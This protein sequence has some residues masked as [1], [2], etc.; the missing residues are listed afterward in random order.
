M[1]RKKE[2]LTERVMEWAYEKWLDGYRIAEIAAAL[3]VSAG[4]LSEYFSS[5][6]Y[7]KVRPPLHPPQELFEE[8][9]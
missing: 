3:H 4:R 8:E 9:A 6:G 5:M 2:V 1:R 7:T